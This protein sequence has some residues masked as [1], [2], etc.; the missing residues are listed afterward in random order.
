MFTHLEQLFRKEE[1]KI[2]ERESKNR[3][4]IHLY[5]VGEYW[6]AFEKSAY[7]LGEHPFS[8]RLVICPQGSPFPLVMGTVHW[9]DIASLCKE[10]ITAVRRTDYLQ[11]LSDT[12]D[13]GMY[14]SWH[15][16]NLKV[17]M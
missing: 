15:N 16:N 10:R 2:L 5:S 17:Y 13:P 6:A 14:R 9:R 1:K 4:R 7:L 12:I 3:D 8:Q 11:L